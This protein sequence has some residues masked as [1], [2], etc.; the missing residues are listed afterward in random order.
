[1]D[2]TLYDLMIRKMRSKMDPNFLI[3]HIFRQAQFLGPMHQRNMRGNI[4][5]V[6]LCFLMISHNDTYNIIR[7]GL[8]AIYFKG[9]Q[10]DIF[11]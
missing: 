2:D 1:M 7:M 11:K 6:I 3:C 4:R 10:V 9:S 8:F 5:S